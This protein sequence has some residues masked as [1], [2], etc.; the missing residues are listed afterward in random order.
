MIVPDILIV[1][2]IQRQM[3]ADI[4]GLHGRATNLTPTVMMYCLQ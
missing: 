1:L 3:V 2:Q 4:A